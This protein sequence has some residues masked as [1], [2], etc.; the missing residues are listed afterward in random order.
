MEQ[1]QARQLAKELGGIA[2]TAR[3]SKNKS[4]WVIGG[5]LTKNHTWV[6]LTQ[7]G[8]IISEVPS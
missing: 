6:V 1:Y 3:P 4:G 7:L 2:T 8:R 5:W